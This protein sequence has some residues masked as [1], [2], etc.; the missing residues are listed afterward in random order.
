M[1]WTRVGLATSKMPA[2][3]FQSGKSSLC[4]LGCL[5]ANPGCFHWA[6]GVFVALEKAP[7]R[8]LSPIR[9]LRLLGRLPLP[10][11]TT[12][13]TEPRIQPLPSLLGGV[14]SPCTVCIL[15]LVLF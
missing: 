4:V 2:D 6:G 15:V 10:R 1:V 7:H 11:L 8:V 13:T 12:E 14:A 5:S 9:C 3:T